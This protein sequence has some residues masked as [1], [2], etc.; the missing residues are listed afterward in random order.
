MLL[1]YIKNSLTCKGKTLIVSINNYRKK[2]TV[3]FQ[4]IVALLK[5]SIIDNFSIKYLVLCIN[6]DL[7]KLTASKEQI[8]LISKMFQVQNEFEQ[9]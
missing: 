6:L 4:K 8:F 2:R 5:M 1:I 3:K 9:S 7:Q